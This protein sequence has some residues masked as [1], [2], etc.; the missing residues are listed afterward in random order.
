MR[1]LKEERLRDFPKSPGQIGEKLGHSSTS[2]GLSLF[3]NNVHRQKMIMSD[4]LL[5]HTKYT[6]DYN[7]QVPLPPKVF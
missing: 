1:K 3:Q 6:N 4:F 5:R 2:V 7:P